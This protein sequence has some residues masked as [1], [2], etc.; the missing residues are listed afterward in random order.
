M[1]GLNTD[2]TVVNR[3]ILEKIAQKYGIIKEAFSEIGILEGQWATFLVVIFTANLTNFG[4]F[5]QFLIEQKPSIYH[6]GSQ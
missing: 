5:V 1:I 3:V 4:Q 2:P 6:W